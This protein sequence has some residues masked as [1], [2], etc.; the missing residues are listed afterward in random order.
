M[1]DFWSQTLKGRGQSEDLG[2]VERI[3]LEWILRKRVESCGLNSSG[4]GQASV[5]GSY[6]HGIEL[7]SSIK[8]GEFDLLSGC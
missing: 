3:I 2:V 7:P 4:A 6:K 1:Q 5:T 8:G